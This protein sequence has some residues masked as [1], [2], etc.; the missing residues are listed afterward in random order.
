MQKFGVS[1][2]LLFLCLALRLRDVRGSGTGSAERSVSCSSG[3]MVETFGEGGDA[4]GM[5]CC[6]GGGGDAGD[7]RSCSSLE[8]VGFPGNGGGFRG[9]KHILCGLSLA[10]E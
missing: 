1:G 3:E 5:K 7:S 8:I 9:S 2:D 6:S 4:G 10:P